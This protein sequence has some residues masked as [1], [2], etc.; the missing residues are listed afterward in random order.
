[1]CVPKIDHKHKRRSRRPPSCAVE[2]I[3]LDGVWAD[4]A[5][6]FGER[7]LVRFFLPPATQHLCTHLPLTTITTTTIIYLVQGSRLQARWRTTRRSPTPSS[8][9][10]RTPSPPTFAPR[11][12][13]MYGR[14]CGHIIYACPVLFFVLAGRSA[15][16]DGGG[17]GWAW[18]RRNGGVGRGTCVCVFERWL[19][20]WLSRACRVSAIPF[21]FFIHISSHAPQHPCRRRCRRCVTSSWRK[22]WLEE[23]S[24]W[25]TRPSESSAPTQKKILVAGTDFECI[26]S[27]Q[28]TPAGAEGVRGLAAGGGEAGGGAGLPQVR[29]KMKAGRIDGWMLLWV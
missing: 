4:D 11:P 19:W 7:A 5:R 2:Q 26:W 28:Y 3:K 13:S 20:A 29:G 10:A 25:N 18:H 23:R 14:G 12:R 22:R 15:R 9:S 6:A 8:E 27:I 1:M 24:V 16:A 17:V 21:P